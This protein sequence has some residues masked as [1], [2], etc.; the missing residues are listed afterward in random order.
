MIGLLVAALL[1][2]DLAVFAA[3]ARVARFPHVV[4]IG[5]W[6]LA[7]SQVSLLAVWLALGRAWVPVRLAAGALVIAGFAVGMSWLP[8]SERAPFW[9]VLFFFQA[10]IAGVP[11]A[12]LHQAG[13][14]WTVSRARSSVDAPGAGVTDDPGG[15]E[16]SLQ[17]RQ[18]SLLYLLAWITA[19][20]I[21]LGAAR[22]L[23]AYGSRFQWPDSLFDPLRRRGDVHILELGV[24]LLGR[25]AVLIASAW[26]VLGNSRRLEAAAITLLSTTASWWM[27]C[28]LRYG[29]AGGPAWLALLH[30]YEVGV[31][32]TALVVVRNAGYRMEWT[33]R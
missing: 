16:G 17:R 28:L 21:V 12:I 8:D 27:I 18:F 6:G 15:V 33:D 7:L 19:V 1:A 5:A 24:F 31:L 4:L 11:L 9:A 30:A 22:S 25:G 13:L 29:F 32:A 26:A 2:A 14:A 20:A 3:G 10:M 23:V